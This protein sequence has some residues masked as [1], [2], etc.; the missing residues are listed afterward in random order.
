ME[1]ETNV[2]SQLP[3]FRGIFRGDISLSAIADNVFNSQIWL[4]SVE[5]YL[6]NDYSHRHKADFWVEPYLRETITLIL[7]KC[8]AQKVC[9]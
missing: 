4:E 1:V 8:L 7:A 5:W 3:A 2:A 9:R 6:R